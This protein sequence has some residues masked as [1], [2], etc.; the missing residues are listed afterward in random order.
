M[1]GEERQASYLRRLRKNEVLARDEQLWCVEWWA[2][3]PSEHA[4]LTLLI[5]AV[6]PYLLNYLFSFGA[7]VD[8]AKDALQN[9][10]LAVHHDGQKFLVPGDSAHATRSRLFTS[11][12]NKW[13]DLLRTA[14]RDNKKVVAL[15]LEGEAHVSHID[16]VDELTNDSVLQY[17]REQLGPRFAI[18]EAVL[19][20]R[21]KNGTQTDWA[22]IGARLGISHDAARARF[23]RVQPEARR[24]L[25]QEG[26]GRLGE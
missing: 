9:L 26:L 13:R 25:Q 20:E 18:I 22:A 6:Q 15:S 11:A 1:T 2:E 21:S 19:E 23:Y 3:R 16:A 17:L 12:L 8:S 7:D 4:R 10:W 5:Y 14:R 24:I